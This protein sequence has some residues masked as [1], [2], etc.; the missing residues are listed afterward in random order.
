MICLIIPWS[1]KYPNQTF[2]CFFV[3]SS[4]M[5]ITRMVAHNYYGS[6]WIHTS[7][8]GYKTPQ[9]SDNHKMSINNIIYT[10]SQNHGLWHCFSIFRLTGSYSIT[11]TSTASLNCM[12]WPWAK[13]KHILFLAG[14]Y[15]HTLTREFSSTNHLFLLLSKVLHNVQLEFQYIL[16]ISTSWRHTYF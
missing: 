9:R 12:T 3:K 7:V 16:I 5:V 4:R 11:L 13:N 2:S 8:T 10:L 15:K 14:F 1:N 6:Y